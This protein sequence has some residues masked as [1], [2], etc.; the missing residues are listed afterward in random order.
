MCY[1]LELFHACDGG[2]VTELRQNLSFRTLPQQESD[3]E[4]HAK[5]LA[6]L[7]NGEAVQIMKPNWKVVRPFHLVGGLV[8]IFGI[9][10]YIGFLII[11]IDVDIFQRGS[12]HQP[13]MV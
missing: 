1:K 12:N 7:K 13:V 3:P 2:S 11:P 4:V 6:K 8:A 9:F 5:M 10:P